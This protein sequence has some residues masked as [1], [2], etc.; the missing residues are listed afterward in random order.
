MTVGNV[1]DQGDRNCLGSKVLRN[2]NDKT[3]TNDADRIF[4]SP[5]AR[6]FAERRSRA[7]SVGRTTFR[8]GMRNATQAVRRA[9]RYSRSR[10]AADRILGAIQFDSIRESCIF[11]A[12]SYGQSIVN[13]SLS[14]DFKTTKIGTQQL[15]GSSQHCE[16]PGYE[17]LRNVE[18]AARGCVGSARDTRHSIAFMNMP[19]YYAIQ[20][21]SRRPSICENSRVLCV[22]RMMSSAC[23]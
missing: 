17:K 23:A 3:A 15:N 4:G 16:T 21:S 5:P 1:Y 11:H 20:S 19:C 12:S 2:K 10:S 13:S 9:A 7:L 22:T 8:I 14:G 6:R 18:G